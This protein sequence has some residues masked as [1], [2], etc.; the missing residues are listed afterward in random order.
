MPPASLCSHDSNWDEADLSYSESTG[1]WPAWAALNPHEPQGQGALWGCRSTVAGPSPAIVSDG[2]AKNWHLCET[3]H[4]VEDQIALC[5][6]LVGD[7][8]VW[9]ISLK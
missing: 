1:S 4:S 6:N 7:E 9:H 2:V 5:L 3:A 8:A